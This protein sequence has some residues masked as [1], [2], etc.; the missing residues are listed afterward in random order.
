MLLSAASKWMFCVRSCSSL[1][2]SSWF[3]CSRRAL[4][5]SRSVTSS[6]VPTQP[7][8]A[9]GWWMILTVRPS[10]S[11]TTLTLVSVCSTSLRTRSMYS[12]RSPPSK[13]PDPSRYSSISRRCVPRLVISRGRPYSWR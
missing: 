7:P 6:W 12:S 3:C 10:P 5:C 11:P 8:V 13:L 9:I 4:S 2:T 1:A